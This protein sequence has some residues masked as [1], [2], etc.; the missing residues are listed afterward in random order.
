MPVISDLDPTAQGYTEEQGDG[1]E[2]LSHYSLFTINGY[3][4]AEYIHFMLP[5]VT[6]NKSLLLQ[7]PLT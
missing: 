4:D 7:T 1:P 3:M 6:L 5:S 2:D